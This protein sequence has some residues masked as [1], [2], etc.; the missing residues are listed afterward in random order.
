MIT[1]IVSLLF[2]V[3]G[4]A[5][6]GAFVNKVFGADPQ[7]KTPCYTS[8]D[9]V[10][11][12]PMPTW[13]VF[14]IQFLN[15]AGTGPIFG[16]IQ[17]ILFGPGAYLWIVLGCVFGGAVHDYMSG[18][19][20]LRKNGASLPEI[21]GDELG[22]T[23]RFALRV[24]SLLLMIL[25]GA[26]FVTT[27]ADILDG[28]MP[29][30][31]F[32]WSKYF[33]VIIIFVYYIL[34]TLLPIDKL[35]GKIYPIFGL[36][37]LIM[38]GG[39]LY[40]IFAYGGSMPEITEAFSNHHPATTMPIFPGLC[41]T[42]ACGAVSGF[43]ATQSPMMAR[44][45]KNEKYGRPIFYGAMITEGLVALIWAAAA[46]KFADSLDV[47]G[48]TPYEKLLTA[49]IN[50]ET[51]KPSPAVLVNAICSNWLGGVGAVLAVLGV[52]AAPITSGDTAFRSARLIAADFMRYKQN[53]IYKRVI[54]SVPLFVVSAVLMFIN[55][56]IL[57]RYFAWFNQSL[58]VITLWAITVWLTKRSAAEGTKRY[59]FLVSLVPALW[60]TIVCSTYI[61]IAPEGFQFTHLV[62][63]IIGG[64]V[65]AG[66]LVWYILWAKKQFA[67]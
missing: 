67:K 40:G 1:F 28:M 21:I 13:K 48:D 38:A 11:Y 8:T 12:M 45:L 22:T 9:G 7:R 46:I 62:S 27:P 2:L 52:V 37:L 26:V 10:D 29:D 55:F 56:D 53:K 24:L 50:P 23:A 57:W 42:I 31:G 59:A 51:G 39:L 32:L 17:G 16:A 30:S 5:L 44:C 43:H 6:Y 47:A 15:I 60:M 65:T 66:V 35:I 33:W 25:V 49:M 18:M 3:V 41:I 34:A 20:S 54:L 58:A 4:Y 63:Y 61:L 19:I 36:A 14:L 64:L